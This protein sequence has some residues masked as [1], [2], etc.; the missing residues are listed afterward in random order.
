[1]LDDNLLN[2]GKVSHIP[3]II[4]PPTIIP[5]TTATP[6]PPRNTN[7]FNLMLDFLH[8]H[9]P[10]YQGSAPVGRQ[11]LRY[12]ILIQFLVPHVAHIPRQLRL[13]GGTFL[14]GFFEQVDFLL[15]AESQI[16]VLGE[17]EPITQIFHDFCDDFVYI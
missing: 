3:I 8:I 13:R 4:K 1:M 16:E 2:F 14:T 17:E 12:Q 9:V 11:L 7:E 6:P 15:L 5:R 10:L